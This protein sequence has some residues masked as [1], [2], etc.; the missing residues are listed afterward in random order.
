MASCFM[1]V[2]GPNRAA[3]GFSSPLPLSLSL[4]LSLQWG[5]LNGGGGGG[6]RVV[7]L[8]Q[9]DPAPLRPVFIRE[10]AKRA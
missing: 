8:I 3:A 5:V 2:D 4:S 9:W 1:R 10:E 6:V 7:Y